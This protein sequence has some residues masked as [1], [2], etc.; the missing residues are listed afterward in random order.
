MTTE[1]A[2]VSSFN[3]ARNCSNHTMNWTRSQVLRFEGVKHFRAE[4]FPGHNKIWGNYSRMPPPRGH[5]PALNPNFLEPRHRCAKQKSTCLE[6][7]TCSR[8]WEILVLTIK[9]IL[10]TAYVSSRWRLRR[11]SIV[12]HSGLQHF[13]GRGALCNSVFFTRHTKPNDWTT[14]I[15][16]VAVRWY[17]SYA[18]VSTKFYSIVK[19]SRHTW[20]CLAA[21]QLA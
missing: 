15:G 14:T 10:K 21:H 7:G 5:G 12:Y 8:N 20:E 19:I 11:G 2:I 3:T 6:N 17:W 16:N 13:W 9:R 4:N 1:L 18:M